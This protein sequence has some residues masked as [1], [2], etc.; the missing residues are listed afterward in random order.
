M[1]EQLTIQQIEERNKISKD[2]VFNLLEQ[3]HRGKYYHDDSLYLT[4]ANK[5]AEKYSGAVTDKEIQVAI[6]NIPKPVLEE[7]DIRIAEL[8]MQLENLANFRKKVIADLEHETEVRASQYP[9]WNLA[10]VEFI[11]S[12]IQPDNFCVNDDE[13]DNDI[14][15]GVEDFY[16]NGEYSLGRSFHTQFKYID[17]DGGYVPF[18]CYAT[19]RSLFPDVLFT[20]QEHQWDPVSGLYDFEL[21]EKSEEQENRTKVIGVVIVALAFI[22]TAIAFIS[23]FATVK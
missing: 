18:H 10:M 14:V 21:K 12:Q 22:L 8:K 13:D 23:S 4:I 15:L 11:K 9:E 6:Y 19:Q 3:I 2:R 7:H 17:Y 5:I 16:A 1:T 20:Y